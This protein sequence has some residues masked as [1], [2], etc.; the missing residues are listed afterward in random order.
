M[1]SNDDTLIVT[2]TIWVLNKVQEINTISH[3]Y[4][5]QKVR[6][7]ALFYQA[8]L[9]NCIIASWPL[10][11]H[12]ENISGNIIQIQPFINFSLML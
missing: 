4:K 7:I 9:W 2:G 10:Y 11:K 6:A 3:L 12:R 5:H 8:C 1:V